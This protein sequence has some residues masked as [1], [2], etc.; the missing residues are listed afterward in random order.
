MLGN[1]F[2]DVTMADIAPYE[3]KPEVVSRFPKLKQVHGDAT[4]GCLSTTVMA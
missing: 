4:P 2:L 1:P 3:I